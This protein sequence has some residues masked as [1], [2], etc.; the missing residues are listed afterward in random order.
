LLTHGDFSIFQDGGR[1]HLEFLKFRNFNEGQDQEDQS[2]LQ[3]EI[4][5]RWVKALVRYGDYSIFQNDG[6]RHL[7]EEKKERRKKERR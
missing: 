2:V 3:Y 5:W 7:G 6:C 4:S 1:R